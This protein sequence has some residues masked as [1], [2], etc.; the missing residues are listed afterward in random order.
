MRYIAIY[1]GPNIHPSLERMKDRPDVEIYRVDGP[2]FEDQIE[3]A[4][5]ND[6]V[7]PLKLAFVGGEDAKE[8]DGQYEGLWI[9]DRPNVEADL[10]RY[11]HL[12]VK[13]LMPCWR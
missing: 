3:M 10:L 12:P 5:L 7:T 4:L 6:L 1:F 13:L 11:W 2:D 8:F 9:E